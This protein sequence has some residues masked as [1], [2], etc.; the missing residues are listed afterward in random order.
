MVREGEEG[1]EGGEGGKEKKD[2][3]R[4]RGGREEGGEGEEGGKETKDGERGRGG[5]EGKE[6]WNGIE[7]RGRQGIVEGTPGMTL[8]DLIRP[9]SQVIMSE[10]Y[11]VMQE[12][13][14]AGRGGGRE[15]EENAN[16][17]T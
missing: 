14:E 7:L 12:R 4:G 8:G 17:N 9:G 1:E 10:D 15:E 5:R 16:K 6:G 2:G 11:C 13:V 3:E